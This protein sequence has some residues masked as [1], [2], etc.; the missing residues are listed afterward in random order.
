VSDPREQIASAL[1]G[2]LTPEQTKILVDEVLAI[3]KK[4]RAE[5]N[6]KDCGKRQIQYAEISDARAV[7]GA[8]TDLMNQGF[9]RP[10]EASV[11]ADPI[12]FIRLTNLGELEKIKPSKPDPKPVRRNTKVNK[13]QVTRQAGSASRKKTAVDKPLQ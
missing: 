1:A 9:G 8:I 2:F 11:H 4:G 13:G 5:F 10:V 6:C 12:N 7:T 3:T